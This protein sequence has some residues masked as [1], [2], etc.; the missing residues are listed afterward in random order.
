MYI[1]IDALI[2]RGM[3]I[4]SQWKKWKKWVCCL[5]SPSAL[6]QLRTCV[7]ES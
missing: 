1:P 2:S 3:P 5:L 4:W 6:V 7:K